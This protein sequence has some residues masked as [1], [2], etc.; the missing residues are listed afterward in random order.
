MLPPAPRLADLD[1]SEL[2]AIARVPPRAGERAAR[3]RELLVARHRNLV[4]SCVRRFRARPAPADDLIQVG[5]VGLM[6]AINNYD[7]A[8]GGSRLA[9]S[10]SITCPCVNSAR[11]RTGHASSI[12]SRIRSR[13]ENPA[14]TGS[15]PSSLSTDN[16]PNCAS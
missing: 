16:D 14:T 5:Y 4:L 2:L 6:K 15:A 13:E 7:P 3:A 1:N 10:A 9:T 8:A 12:T 11:S